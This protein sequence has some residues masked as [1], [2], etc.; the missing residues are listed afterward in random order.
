MLCA[1]IIV[2]V[3][4]ADQISKAIVVANMEV[5]G[6]VDFIPYVLS[7]Y[8]SE[9]TGIAWGMLSNHRWVFIVV[10][11]VA[12]LGFGFFYYKTKKPHLLYTVS[13]GFILGGGVGNMIDRLFR[14][15]VKVDQNAVVDFLK[16]DFTYLPAFENIP[17]LGSFPIFNVADCFITVGSVL[18]FAYL[19]FLD[20]KQQNPVLFEKKGKDDERADV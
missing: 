7:F 19:L 15:G 3:I 1:L 20:S 9:N 12:L 2:G 8:R 4:V 10:S 11:V 18:M 5:G 13:M 17:I 16:L 14:P 6:E